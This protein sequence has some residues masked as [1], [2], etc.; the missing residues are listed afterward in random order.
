MVAALFVL[1]NAAQNNELTAALAGG[2]G[3]R[4]IAMVPFVLSIVVAVALFAM[5]ETVGANQD[6]WRKSP[7][8]STGAASRLP[9]KR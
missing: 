4:R 3:L 1:G 2:I 6:S 5:A 8:Q 7:L 9:A